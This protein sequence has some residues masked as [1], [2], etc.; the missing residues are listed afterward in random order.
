MQTLAMLA[1]HNRHYYKPMGLIRKLNCPTWLTSAI[2]SSH[3]SSQLMCR[4]STIITF[5]PVLYGMIN[6]NEW[7][8]YIP[9]SFCV[10]C[11]AVKHFP[12]WN[13]MRSALC[14]GVHAW[15]AGEGVKEKIKCSIVLNVG[16]F[17]LLSPKLRLFC[18]FNAPWRVS[19]HKRLRPTY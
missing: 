2:H 17:S 15:S 10:D 1:F 18:A 12:L 14:M 11:V 19:P 8:A 16:K 6:C 5:V 4:Y 7:S 13:Y 9:F 3:D